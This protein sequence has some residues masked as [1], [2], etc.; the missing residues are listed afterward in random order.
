METCQMKFSTK[1]EVLFC[2]RC[3]Y[4]IKAKY[5]SFIGQNLTNY[6]IC[7]LINQTHY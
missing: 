2:R 3:H 4:H 1:E 5:S 7:E 6:T